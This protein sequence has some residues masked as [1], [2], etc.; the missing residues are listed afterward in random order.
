MVF[1]F[2][3]PDDISTPPSL[4]NIIIE[5]END[6]NKKA[7]VKNNLDSWAKQGVFL[8]N[9]ILTVVAHKPE[10]HRNIGWEW[11][12]DK[13][14][15]TLSNEKEFC[16][17]VLWGNYAKSKKELIDKRHLILEAT[18]PSPFSA[19]NGFFGCKHFSKNKQSFKRKRA[20]RN[21][22]VIIYQE[23]FGF[24]LHVKQESLHILFFPMFQLLKV[25]L[26]MHATPSHFHSIYSLPF[27]LLF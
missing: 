14:I 16:I 11:F 21:R 26:L 27:L 1:V 6:T 10:S 4:R 23:H 13:V 9:S 2:P 20:K 18:H 22:L 17:F 15:E 8:L 19:H 5:I 7:S 24:P 12:T 3:V 25:S